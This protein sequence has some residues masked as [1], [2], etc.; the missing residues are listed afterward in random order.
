MKYFY[1]TIFITL[2]CSCSHSPTSAYF[3][4]EIVNPTT[5]HVY[6]YWNNTVIDSALLNQDNRFS[7]QIDNI[8]E[9]LYHFD[10]NEYQY[11]VLEKGDSLM[12]RLNT[13]DFDES[14]VFTGKGAIK[15]NF[16]MDMFLI[17]ED[18][19]KAVNKYSE[20][21]AGDF[22]A[23]IDSLRAMKQELLKDL[24]EEQT[25]SPL[26]LHIAQSAI[27]YRYF[28]DMEEYPFIH[29]RRT[30]KDYIEKLPAQFYT[31]RENI[32]YN[33]SLLTYYSP[34]FNYLITHFNNMALGACKNDC[35]KHNQNYSRSTHYS[36]HKLKLIDSLVTKNKTVR[37][38][39]T[40]NA[41]FS[42]LLARHN[43]EENSE[44]M[45]AFKKYAVHNQHHEEIDAFYHNV[46]QMQK[47]LEI[48]P[49]HLVTING[50]KLTLST[51][52]YKKN[53]VFYFWNYHQRNHLSNV[54]T[55]IHNLKAKYPEFDYIGINVNNDQAHWLQNIASIKDPKDVENQYR[56]DNVDELLSTLVIKNLNKVIVVDK[57]GK[58]E[59]GFANIYYT[60]QLENILESIKN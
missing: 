30:G 28:T 24:N 41:A 17:Y 26:S 33:D 31:F 15:N 2:T 1:L 39:L 19:E 60:R 12:V 4:G 52:H 47:G 29:R 46:Q 7:F 35:K 54:L 37:D 53:T 3:G 6:L 50:E 44:F 32:S 8:K 34:Y 42:Y 21:D 10:H 56:T 13:L 58:I 5:D 20:L 16:L 45:T 23:K 55:R 40:R 27:N 51:D 36:I 59:E 14:L 11:I 43:A 48:P 57:D 25:L 49:L 38:N 9:G 18:E 22:M